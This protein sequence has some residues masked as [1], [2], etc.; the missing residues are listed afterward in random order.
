ME[1]ETAKFKKDW[2]LQLVYGSHLCNTLHT[3]T[4]SLREGTGSRAGGVDISELMWEQKEQSLRLLL[5]M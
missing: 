5:Q 2:V 3:P 4:P 1:G